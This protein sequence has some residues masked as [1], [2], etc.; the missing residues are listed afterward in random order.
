MAQKLLKEIEH[1]VSVRS[2]TIAEY[3]K[4]FP[5]NVSSES[6]KW[7]KENMLNKM[8]K[9][10]ADIASKEKEVKQLIKEIKKMEK[11]PSKDISKTAAEAA[12]NWTSALYIK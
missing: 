5:M 12:K 2:E 4:R 3:W 11:H 8:K 9:L 6:D 7:V 1:L 10:W